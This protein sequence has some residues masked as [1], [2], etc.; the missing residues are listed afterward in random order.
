MTR[1]SG[2]KESSLVILSSCHLVTLLGRGGGKALD[3]LVLILV[4]IG[5]L[6]QANHPKDFLEVL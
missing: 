3:R 1:R 2:D 6:R 5:I 4:D